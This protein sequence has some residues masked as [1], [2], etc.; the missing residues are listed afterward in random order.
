MGSFC[1][2][3]YICGYRIIDS[4]LILVQLTVNDSADQY[5][6]I[7]GVAPDRENQ[8]KVGVY[9]GLRVPCGYTGG[10]LLGRG[11]IQGLYVHMGFHPA[12]KFA[13]VWELIFDR[14]R[15]VTFSDRSAKMAAIREDL[16]TTPLGPDSDR[17][18][19]IERWIRDS[20]DQR[21]RY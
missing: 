12:W 6:S 4:E 20:F 19:D 16:T 11:F 14:G 17:P 21:Y 3:G 2:Q 7:G 13:E 9:S 5:P 8:F 15:V 18:K 1:W 10:L